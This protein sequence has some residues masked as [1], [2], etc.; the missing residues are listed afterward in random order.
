[1]KKLL[2]VLLVL[3]MVLAFVTPL[4]AE[5]VTLEDLDARVKTLEG[6]IGTSSGELGIG[7]AYKT[8]QSY[9]FDPYVNFTVGSY[10]LSGATSLSKG[11]L[12][13]DNNYGSFYG[14]IIFND[15]VYLKLT[16][17]TLKFYYASDMVTVYG[18]C[19]SLGTF[20]PGS[21]F[22][23]AFSSAYYAYAY[24]LFSNTTLTY[25]TY[26]ADTF[27]VYAGLTLA[28]I[29]M[30]NITDD[31]KYELNGSTWENTLVVVLT[32]VDMFELDIT[33]AINEDET[34]NLGVEVYLN[35]L[36]PV[37]MYITVTLDD[38][39]NDVATTTLPFG[40]GMLVSLDALSIYAK[41]ASA[42]LMASTMSIDY[43]A[44]L[45]VPEVLFG[46]DLYAGAKGSTA[47]DSDMEIFGALYTSF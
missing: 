40:M 30:L 1:M 46:F 24:P 25:T 20:E 28:P 33:F 17:S 43:E 47:S 45:K 36:G 7:F 37:S 16:D 8:D 26:D 15:N 31:F 9:L 44:G 3:T 39:V 14:K 21:Y 6:G 13:V 12:Y 18:G 19:D 10:A 41:V 32:P 35:D 5:G 4:F 23:Y 11:M 42:D 27:Y 22:G 29:D 2:A 34:K 38:F